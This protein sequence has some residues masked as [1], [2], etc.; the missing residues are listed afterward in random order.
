VPL[1]ERSEPTRY[2]TIVADPPWQQNAGPEWGGRG[3]DTWTKR[4]FGERTNTPTL[5]LDYPTMPLDAICEVGVAEVAEADS[6]LYLWT[7]NRYIADAYVV[8]RAWGFRP[9]TL[10][11][12]CKTPKGLGLGG[13]FVQTTEH[14]LFARRGSLAPLKR[15][16]TTWFDFARPIGH[17]RKPD[18]FLDVVEQVSPGPYLEIFARR[19]R[20]GWDYAGD[21]S[22]GTVEIPGLRSPDEEAAA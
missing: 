10:L 11:T 22:L 5:A 12:W 7:T 2:R 4:N 18:G 9:V 8:A 1:P 20:F 16:P 15:W 3:N 19:A 6:H 21:G 14:V 17:S 13:A